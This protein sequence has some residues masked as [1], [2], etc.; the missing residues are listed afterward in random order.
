VM[1]I[2]LEINDTDEME[3][4]ILAKNYSWLS[5]GE[6]DI[7]KKIE[8][9]EKALSYYPDYIPPHYWLGKWYSTRGYVKFLNSD[10]YQA[11]KDRARA[12]WCFNTGFKLKNRFK[13]INHNLF[14]E[15]GSHYYRWG[16]YFNARTQFEQEIREIQINQNYKSNNINLRYIFSAKINII[17]CSCKSGA[18]PVDLYS[19]LQELCL[20]NPYHPYVYVSIGM[21]NCKEGNYGD[22]LDNFNKSIEI[23]PDN[24]YPY[25]HKARVFLRTNNQEQAQS[26]FKKAFDLIQTSE[27][28]INKIKLKRWGE[29]NNLVEKDT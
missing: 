24:Y 5:L 13:K 23:K 20:E 8:Y 15:W 17:N 2:L 1:P 14:N 25:W 16:D 26:C 12:E 27:N 4:K 29:K 11:D 9:N 7:E 21:L 10:Q 6:K 19:Q 18:N 28:E 22:A 3:K